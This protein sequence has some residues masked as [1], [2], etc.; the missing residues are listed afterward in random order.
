[1]RGIRIVILIIVNDNRDDNYK[2][3]LI[4]VITI[5]IIFIM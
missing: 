5:I 1:M 2:K 4:R 3:T